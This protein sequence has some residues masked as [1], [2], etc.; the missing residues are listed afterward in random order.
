ME[1]TLIKNTRREREIVII[2]IHSLSISSDH[3]VHRM[4]MHVRIYYRKIND[5]MHLTFDHCIC[6]TYNNSLYMYNIYTLKSVSVII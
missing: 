6:I 1:D 2:A 5:I 4:S 3:Y